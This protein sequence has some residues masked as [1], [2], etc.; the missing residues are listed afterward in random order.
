MTTP[1]LVTLIILDGFGIAPPRRGNAISLA[2]IPFFDKLVTTYPTMALQ[3]SGKWLA[4][5][6]EKWVTPKWVI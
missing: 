1:N 2:N 6:G 3:S 4:C 5:L